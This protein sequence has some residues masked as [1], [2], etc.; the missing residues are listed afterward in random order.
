MQTAARTGK[1]IGIT[2]SVLDE[3]GTTGQATAAAY[4]QPVRRK[5]FPITAH[6]PKEVR[7]QLKGLAFELDTTMH[8]LIA[9]VYN[10]LL[11]KHGKPR[12]CPQTE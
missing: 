11:A 5:A 9:D 12:I 1:A 7:R 6:F 3:T 10:G 4:K 2:Y 8:A